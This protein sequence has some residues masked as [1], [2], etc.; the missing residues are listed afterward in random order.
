MNKYKGYWYDINNT[1]EER[2]IIIADNENDAK[3]KFYELYN[4]NPPLKLLSV[5]RI[6]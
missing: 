1:I 4:G 3:M 5:I 6:E 2:T